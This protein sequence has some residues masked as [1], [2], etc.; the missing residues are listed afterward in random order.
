MRNAA[1]VVFRGALP[2]R[3][4]KPMPTRQ[5]ASGQK[6]PE[7]T[8]KQFN[9]DKRAQPQGL[10]PFAFQSQGWPG[11]RFSIG[12]PLLKRPGRP[13]KCKTG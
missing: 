4:E 7:G 6:G 3:F 1:G 5:K 8:G 10:R 9:K 2:R 13:C 12:K 11:I